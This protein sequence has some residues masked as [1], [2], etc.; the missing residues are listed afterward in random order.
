MLPAP[1]SVKESLKRTATAEA[2]MNL[3][4]LD[5]HF[6][7]GLSIRKF[8]IDVST[9]VTSISSGKIQAI[10]SSQVQSVRHLAADILGRRSG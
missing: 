3:Q 5:G 8:L 7:F 1:A 2:S 9:S 4:Y 6:V 10:T